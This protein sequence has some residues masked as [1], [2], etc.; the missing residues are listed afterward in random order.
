[1]ALSS[2]AVA[3][4]TQQYRIVLRRMGKLQW[5]AEVGGLLMLG[6]CVGNARI[7]APRVAPVENLEPRLYMSSVVWANAGTDW[8]SGAN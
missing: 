4:L 5:L 6:K 7:T 1:M 8:N 3:W 2:R